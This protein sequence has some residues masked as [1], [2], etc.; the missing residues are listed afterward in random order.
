MVLQPRPQRKPGLT[1]PDIGI[2]FDS[3]QTWWDL[4][5][6]WMD[7][8]ARCQYL[9]QQ[10]QFVADVAVLTGEGAPNALV[11]RLGDPVDPNG[12]LDASTI[13]EAMLRRSGQMPA[14]PPAG[15]D[16][17]A[18]NANAV[19]RMTVEGERL[20]LPGGM[21]YRL[22][23]LPPEKRMT[24]A[25]AR[26]VRELVRAGA[27]VVG[28]KPQGS[29]SLADGPQGDV[30]VSSIA[31]EVWA[32]CDG[33][34]ASRHAFGKGQVFSCNAIG[35]AL[36]AAKLAPDFTFTAAGPDARQARVDF[37]HRRTDD[38][39]IYFVSNQRPALAEVRCTFRTSGRQPEIWLPEMGQ[40]I[41]CRAFQQQQGRT[42]LPLRL[43]PSGSL[44]VVFRKPIDAK[45]AGKAASNFPDT[46]ALFTITGPWTVRFDPRWGGPEKTVFKGLQ[47]WSRRPESGIRYYSGTASYCK[48][49][50]INP[51]QLAGGRPLYLD[52]GVV[53]ELAR[54]RLNGK[55]MGVLWKPPFTVDVT[56]ALRPGRNDLEVQVTN[57]WP[58]RLIG[59]AAL[60]VEKRLATVNWN[61]FEADSPLL[62]S[63][64]I[65]PVQITR[66]RDP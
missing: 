51:A 49:F 30:E 47:S 1:W 3:T 52:L 16:F 2:N 55:D 10:G 34:R 59:D 21:S 53:K 62:E 54:L 43:A 35:A 58:N 20:T 5:G 27:T 64:L 63:G 65:G 61:P 28:P 11:R 26:K 48:Q 39:E 57:L 22:L 38:A 37:I 33:K 56:S 45:I 7:Y 12:R 42:M 25:L 15:Y 8:L 36:A 14:L 31:E 13:T 46:E 29:P 32:D 6:A 60:P 66:D 18:V 17:D 19:L 40:V 23:V 9:L 41:P 50:Q 24:L 44:F 4:A